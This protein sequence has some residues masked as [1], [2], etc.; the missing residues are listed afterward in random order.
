MDNRLFPWEWQRPI[1]RGVTIRHR[2][3]VVKTTYGAHPRLAKTLTEDVWCSGS[4]VLA[5][6]RSGSV[7]WITLSR[8]HR[9]LP[10]E[11]CSGFSSSWRRS[12]KSHLFC[13]CV[14]RRPS[15]LRRHARSVND[16]FW[17][18]RTANIG[19]MSTAILGTGKFPNSVF[20]IV[21]KS[22]LLD[23]ST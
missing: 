23:V 12:W 7:G 17:I 4:T 10:R 8:C 21:Q 18:V 14:R 22:M 5:V 16:P 13:I 6:V 9:C 1:L 3:V 15:H 19:C 11:T 20:G 2:T